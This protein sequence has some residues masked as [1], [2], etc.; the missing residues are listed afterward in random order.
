VGDRLARFLKATQPGF[1]SFGTGAYIDSATDRNISSVILGIHGLAYVNPDTPSCAKTAVSAKTT[2]A[3]PVGI[4]AAEALPGD[5]RAQI[6]DLATAP[7]G[8]CRSCRFTAPLNTAGLC[9]RCA[10]GF[11]ASPASSAEVGTAAEVV[12]PT[13]WTDD[14]AWITEIVRH[15]DPRSD[16]ALALLFAWVLAAGGWID[17]MTADLPTL[18]HRYAT[19]ELRRML[20]RSGI[21][22]GPPP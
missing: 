7:L 15:K 5:P 20:R 3:A 13:G 8:K 10:C 14:R 4:V 22:I 2:S 18:P 6:P 12:T 19:Q 11:G 9:G 21:E 1:G 17:G 16:P